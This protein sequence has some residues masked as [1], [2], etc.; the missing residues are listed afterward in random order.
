MF[1]HLKVTHFL[2]LI[3]FLDSYLQYG[4]PPDQYN[5]GINQGYPPNGQNYQNYNRIQ[6][7]SQNSGYSKYRNFVNQKDIHTE[8]GI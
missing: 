7:P 4:P 8:R 1:R 3:Y 5:P 2:R 6:A